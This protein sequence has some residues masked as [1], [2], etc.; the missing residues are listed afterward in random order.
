M[1]VKGLVLAIPNNIVEKLLHSLN[2]K[3]DCHFHLAQQRSLSRSARRS[4][5][6][7][8]NRYGNNTNPRFVRRAWFAS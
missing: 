2:I 3:E 1:I 5:G 4:A 8:T 6:G 7:S